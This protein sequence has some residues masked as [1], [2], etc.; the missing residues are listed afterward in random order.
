ME[1][2]RAELDRLTDGA[3]HQGVAIEV[4]EYKYA[5]VDEL[6]GRAGTEKPLLVALDGVTDPQNLG[7]VIRSGAAFGAHGV[8]LPARR[9]A[10]VNVT[11]WKVSAGAAARMGVAQVS[12]L[13]NTLKE[14]QRAGCFVLGLDGDGDTSIANIP[15]ATEGVVLVTGAEGKGLSHLV[16]RTCDLVVSIPISADMESLNAA[17]AT[18]IALYQISQTRAGNPA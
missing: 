5:S 8:I 9:S 2:T 13:V 4:P 7:A 3:V 17:V 1:V 15:V 10:G 6:L 14:L 11:V 16:R 18:G 12:N